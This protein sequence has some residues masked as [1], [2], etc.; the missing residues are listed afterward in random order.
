[1]TNNDA[2][3]NKLK[4]NVAKECLSELSREELE[5]FAFYLYVVTSCFYGE[6]GYMPKILPGH[7]LGTEEIDKHERLFNDVVHRMVRRKTER[8]ESN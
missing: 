2:V 6:C 5:S 7:S 8:T 4:C 1:M 3:E